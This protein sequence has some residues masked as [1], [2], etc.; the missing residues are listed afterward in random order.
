MCRERYCVNT[1]SIACLVCSILVLGI[2][3]VLF[4]F[5]HTVLE[6]DTIISYTL[7][8]CAAMFQLYTVL[9]V[10]YMYSKILQYRETI[11]DMTPSYSISSYHEIMAGSDN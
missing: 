9:L 11:H 4:A 3:A 5:R 10:A 8:G 2:N 1:L 6:I 7:L